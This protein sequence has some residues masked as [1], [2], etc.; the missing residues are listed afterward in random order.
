MSIS[1]EKLFDADRQAALRERL[2]R[3]SDLPDVA[4][5]IHDELASFAHVDGIYVKSL[6]KSELPVALAILA[7][8]RD[9]NGQLVESAPREPVV[10][11]LGK[12]GKRGGGNATFGS[13]VTVSATLGASTGFF[14]GAIGGIVGAALVGAGATILCGKTFGLGKPEAIDHGQPVVKLDT[15]K[16]CDGLLQLFGRIDDL[17][18]AFGEARTE[19]PPEQPPV[20]LADFPEFLRMF[21]L[22]WSAVMS[23]SKDEMVAIVQR[24]FPSLLRGQGLEVVRLS[25]E[26]LRAESPDHA[27]MKMCDV[28]FRG[29]VKA[30]TL[31]YPPICGKDAVVLKG[32][33]LLPA[34]SD[35]N[36]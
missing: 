9:S 7:L 15:Q 3:A 23:D 22:M 11:H 30:P 21:Q 24:Q 14:L 20:T 26:A 35:A 28:E 31:D 2:G 17:V 13:I 16:V 34:K 33:V 32:N 25:D 12:R 5:A 1:L 10:K 27:Q 18:R 19:Q 36:K 29:D 4:A 8:V 6:T